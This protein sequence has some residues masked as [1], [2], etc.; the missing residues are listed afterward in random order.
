ME[1]HEKERK[2]L[3]VV[4]YLKENS[5][6]CQDFVRTNFLS[7]RFESQKLKKAFEWYFSYWNDFVHPGFFSLTYEAMGGQVEEMLKP[8]AALAMIAAALDIHDDII[9]DS[10][11]K[12]N[13]KTVFGKFGLDL[14]LLLG[15][16]FLVNGFALLGDFAIQL[17]DEDGKRIFQIEK[18]C[19]F[20]VGTAHVAEFEARSKFNF[21]PEKYLK[22]LEMKA[23]SVEADMQIAAIAAGASQDRV[24]IAKEYGRIIGSLT[25]LREEFVDAFEPEELNRRINKEVLPIPFMY[26][27]KSLEERKQIIK[28]LEKKRITKRDTDGLPSI[29]LESE[30]VVRLKEYMRDLSRRGVELSSKMSTGKSRTLLSYL[31]QSM[32]EDL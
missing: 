15:N 3:V 5:R 4:K 30:P 20:E 7:R 25:T 16:A 13:H 24:K 21:F 27:L 9:D 6:T 8:Q 14:C 28:L 26:A 19:L 17:P 18:S 12:H 32:L 31:A 10:E 2:S 22:I 29:V 11:R 1:A 23:A